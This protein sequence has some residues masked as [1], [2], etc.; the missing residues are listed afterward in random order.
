MKKMIGPFEQ[1]N[2][3]DQKAAMDVAIATVLI[4]LQIPSA[5]QPLYDFLVNE[6]ARCHGLPRQVVRYALRHLG[7]ALYTQNWTLTVQKAESKV[8][9]KFTPDSAPA[10]RNGNGEGDNGSG[11][12]PQTP[13]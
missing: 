2:E 10:S 3:A 8:V 4:S 6:F 7:Q 11:G 12:V 1:L 13:G 5:G 9:T